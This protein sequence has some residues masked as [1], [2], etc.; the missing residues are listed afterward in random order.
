MEELII[1]LAKQVPSLVI[2][3]WIVLH[4]LK[5]IRELADRCHACQDKS[6]DAILMFSQ[7]INKHTEETGKMNKNTLVTEV[8]KA[9]SEIKAAK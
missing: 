2:L 6:S 9:I 7:S 4:F 5:N 8:R 1:E 3:A